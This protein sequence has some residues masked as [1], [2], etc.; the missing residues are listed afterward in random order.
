MAE[1]LPQGLKPR[2]FCGFCAGDKSPAYLQDGLLVVS[3]P[4]G[5]LFEADGMIQFLCNGDRFDVF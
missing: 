5:A 2:F 3:A 1:V 4:R